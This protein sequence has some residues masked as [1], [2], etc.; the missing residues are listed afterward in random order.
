M[1]CQQVPERGCILEPL[2]DLPFAPSLRSSVNTGGCAAAACHHWAQALLYLIFI[3]LCL[4]QP[5]SS[6]PPSLD[7]KQAC[8]PDLHLSTPR[9][10][11][12]YG[13]PWWNYVNGYKSQETLLFGK[14]LKCQVLLSLWISTARCLCLYRN[15]HVYLILCHSLLFPTHKLIGGGI[16]F[17]TSCCTKTR[18]LHRVVQ[19]LFARW[20]NI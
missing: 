17:Y 5:H 2:Q 15:I 11:S 4:L 6:K 9:L 16:T 8:S 3:T 7:P 19:S 13:Y 20:M 1:W 10:C 18:T 12:C 14:P